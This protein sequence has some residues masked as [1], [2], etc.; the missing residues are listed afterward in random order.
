MTFFG[1]SVTAP[2]A[3]E[4]TIKATVADQAARYALTTDDVQNGDYVYQTDTGILY[5]VTDQTALNGAGGY[6]AQTGFAPATR[7]ISTTAP[8]TG[9][10][11]LSANRT[12]AMPAAESGVSG[13]LTAADWSTFNAK[14]QAL[15]G[16]ADVPGMSSISGLLKVASGV[17]SAAVAGTDYQAPL[18]GLTYTESTKAFSVG[19]YSGTNPYIAMSVAGLGTYYNVPTGDVHRFLVNGI[20]K[21]CLDTGGLILG[22]SIGTST[23]DR[24]L[25][26]VDA[27]NPQL[28][29]DDGTYTC[30]MDV[31]NGALHLSFDGGST[32]YSVDVTA[33]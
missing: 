25:H 5:E 24:R 11:D 4:L 32:W 7:T 28:R 8:L 27:T 30:D 16:L 23:S 33:V 17:P 26:V 1:G 31:Q 12:L 13:Y 22:N 21:G 2:T 29:L 6:T 20:E 15:T 3:A 14:Q 9:G 19:T 10:G 18:T